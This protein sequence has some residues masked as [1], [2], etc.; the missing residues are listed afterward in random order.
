MPDKLRPVE[1]HFGARALAPEAAAALRDGS[2]WY[3]SYLDS[4]T[5]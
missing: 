3:L 2:V 1:I 5:V 4:D